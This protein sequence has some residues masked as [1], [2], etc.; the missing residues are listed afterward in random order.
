MS[1]SDY[2]ESV[3]IDDEDFDRKLTKSFKKNGVAVVTNVFSNRECR[4][5]MDSIVDDFCQLGTGIDKNNID[6]TWT[7]Y[8]LP[9]QT[10]HG[11]FQTTMSNL[12]A[13]WT[14][15]SDPNVRK[16]FEILY[17]NLREEDIDEFIVSGDGINIRPGTVGPYASNRDW[18]HL[19]QTTSGNI[20]K[21]VQGQAI[22]TTTSASFRA[23]PGSHKYFEEILATY[24]FESKSNWHK[25]TPEEVPKI[26][27]YLEKKGIRWQI[28][29]L[30][31]KGSFIVWAST[32]IHSAKLQDAK[33]SPTRSDPYNG[34]RGVVYVCYRPL[35]EF[36]KTQIKKRQ[37]VFDDNRLTNHW[38]TNMFG[39]KPGSRYIYSN[40]RHEV[41]EDLIQN[42]KNFYDIIDKPSLSRD[43]KALLGY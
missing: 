11:L 7:V 24:K 12:S 2:F 17:S 18:P 13:V 36:T 19:D 38:S 29:I 25:F 8:N 16:I 5:L 20:Y 3:S 42:P 28:P 43:Q 39:K 10:R 1:Q 15:R 35:S 14:V 26:K 41:I 4:D 32:T 33:E 9:P 21:C 30:A 22:L 37:K 34:W 40:P 31:P 27:Q 23:T 6:E